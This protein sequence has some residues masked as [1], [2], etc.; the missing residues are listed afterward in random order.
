MSSPL[1]LQRGGQ[2]RGLRNYSICFSCSQ[3]TSCPLPPEARVRPGR[4]L[5]E[6]WHV[7]SA[8]HVLHSMQ[9]RVAFRGEVWDG[10]SVAETERTAAS[11]LLVTLEAL[12]DADGAGRTGLTVSEL[13]RAVQR[14]KSAM[15]RQLGP[16]VDLGL[17]ERTVDGRHHVGWRLFTLA[18]KAGEQRLLLLA[19][20]VMRRLAAVTHERVHLSV[21]HGRDVLTVLSESSHRVIEAVGWVGRTSPVYCTSSGRALLF[22]HTDA[23]VRALLEGVTFSAQ[24]PAAPCDLNALLTRLAQ[25]RRRGYAAVV[26]EFDPDLMAVAAPIRDFSGRVIAALNV[27]AP[28]FRLGQRLDSTGQ[29]VAAAAA[30]LSSSLTSAPLTVSQS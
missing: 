20:S 15:S 30:H 13:A 7:Q 27:S 14:D 25:A 5:Y 23:E 18:A 2:A 9:L 17:V 1:R 11:R 28:S 12:S 16:L 4:A 10:L 29:Q 8:E 6:G 21:R 24:G 22:E 3:F 19:P 26:G